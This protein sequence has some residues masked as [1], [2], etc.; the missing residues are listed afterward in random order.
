MI[1]LPIIGVMGSRAEKHE[2]FTAQLG[3]FL[4]ENAF[5]LLTGGGTGTMEAVSEAFCR[6]K[7]RQG[8]TM[9]VIPTKPDGEGRYVSSNPD[10]PN[11]FVEIPV[12][13]PL[14]VYENYEGMPL[15]RNHVNVMTSEALVFL[16]GGVGTLNEY[17][18]AVRFQKSLICFGPL[19]RLNIFP[20]QEMKTDKI[21]EV[22]LF[23]NRLFPDP[24]I[25]T[26]DP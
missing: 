25:P 6:V 2:A 9:G 18:L 4:A 7:E 5:H 24:R 26:P 23:L 20:D 13:T 14:G 12:Y 11:P 1:R 8:R 3:R 10:Y 17:N 16:P 15:S 21:E 19:E 22:A